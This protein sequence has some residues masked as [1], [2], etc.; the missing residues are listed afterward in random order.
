MKAV[1]SLF[2]AA[3]IKHKLKENMDNMVIVPSI[4]ALAAM[5][6]V[7]GIPSDRVGVLLSVM[8]V[9]EDGPDKYLIMSRKQYEDYKRQEDLI[10][11]EDAYS[12]V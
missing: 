1:P 5:T 11:N 9:Q 10:L 2:Q 4:E 8:A 3:M 7:H 6:K 12:R